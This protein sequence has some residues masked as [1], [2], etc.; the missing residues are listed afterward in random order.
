MFG[1]ELDVLLFIQS[2]RTDLLNMLFQGVTMLGEEIIIV[3]LVAV[4]YF[5]IDKLFAQKLL[6]TLLTSIGINGIVKNLV[7]F[8][9]P[10]STGKITCVREGT[11]TGYSFPSGHTQSFATTSTTIAKKVKKVW[12]AIIVG[13]LIALVAFSRLYLGAHYPSDVVVGAVLGITIAIVGSIL[14]DNIKNKKWLYLGTILIELPFVI[15][16]LITPDVEYEDFFKAFGMIVGF[17]LA[18]MFEEKYAP[19]EY[20]IGTGKKVLRVLIGVALALIV[21]EG[22]KLI[23]VSNLLGVTLLLESLR[24][25]MLIFA[26]LGIGPWIFKKLKI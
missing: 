10:F 11:E 2:M 16:F 24:Y 12:V 26:T 8:P 19:L 5:C 22:L 18:V 6:Y 15:F 4:L 13:I 9:R 1:F 23:F 20:N 17:L 21:K 7:K 25:G 14:F 3:L